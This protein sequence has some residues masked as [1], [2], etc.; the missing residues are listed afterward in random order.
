MGEAGE[1]L[2]VDEV[3]GDRGFLFILFDDRH[4]QIMTKA[5]FGIKGLL[6]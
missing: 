4:A 5:V 6:S 1:F 2:A 3:F